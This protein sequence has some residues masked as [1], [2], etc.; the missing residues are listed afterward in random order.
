MTTDISLN[1]THGYR[2]GHGA[3]NQVVQY[4]TTYLGRT[5]SFRQAH[6]SELNSKHTV[7]NNHSHQQQRGNNR[8]PCSPDKSVARVMIADPV[9]WWF[10]R[11]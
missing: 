3:K 7:L 6:P 11:Q 5:E 1:I 8:H 2:A 10:S 9:G 4:H